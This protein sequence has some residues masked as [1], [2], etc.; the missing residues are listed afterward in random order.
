MA[1]AQRRSVSVTRSRLRGAEQDPERLIHLDKR[2]TEH[3]EQRGGAAV[4]N[5]ALLT[6]QD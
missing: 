4:K 2:R 3:M 1:E 5:T 6:R